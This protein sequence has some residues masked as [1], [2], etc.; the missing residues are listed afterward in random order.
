MFLQSI[1]RRQVIKFF[2]MSKLKRLRL[3]T[4]CTT[5]PSLPPLTHT[6]NNTINMTLTCNLTSATVLNNNNNNNNNME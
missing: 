3:K 5:F 6:R 4:I 2:K 1:L